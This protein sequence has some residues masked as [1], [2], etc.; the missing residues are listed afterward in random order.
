M[1][2]AF[3]LIAVLVVLSGCG[4]DF[5]A[6][7]DTDGGGRDGAS[8]ASTGDGGDAG[9]CD[10]RTCGPACKSGSTCNVD[11][12]SRSCDLGCSGCRGDFNCT[13]SDNCA[14][15]CS[16]GGTC[17]VTC[18][19]DNCS[20]QCTGGSHC[21]LTCADRTKTCDIQCDGVKRI[22]DNRVVTCNRDCPN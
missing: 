5:D 16:E 17:N 8:E 2:R 11:C 18:T 13:G 10:P 3:H 7:F 21:T 19:S 12:N 4:R 15:G 14:V 20:I 9:V 1:K 6:L 22:C